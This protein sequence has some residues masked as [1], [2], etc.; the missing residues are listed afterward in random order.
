MSGLQ[1][2]RYRAKGKERQR[3]PSQS[4]DIDEEYEEHI[5]GLLVRDTYSILLVHVV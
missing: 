5:A 1:D 4:H 3:E 2:I